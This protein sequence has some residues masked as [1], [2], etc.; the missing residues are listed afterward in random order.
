MK[1]K[2]VNIGL[3]ALFLIS[4][5]IISSLSTVY[6]YNGR[7]N[8]GDYGSFPNFADEMISY[9]GAEYWNND[10]MIINGVYDNPGAQENVVGWTNTDLGQYRFKTNDF[11]GPTSGSGSVILTF[12]IK[13]ELTENSKLLVKLTVWKWICGYGCG[14][15]SI[16]TYTNEITQGEITTDTVTTLNTAIS[17]V[18]FSTSSKYQLL[19]EVTNDAWGPTAGIGRSHFYEGASDRYCELQKVEITI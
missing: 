4:F 13:G 10:Q 8:A 1:I 19:I 2:Y 6:T 12:K 11:Y 16:G 17:S 18:T 7:K 5:T 9:D 3:F 14:Y 15:G